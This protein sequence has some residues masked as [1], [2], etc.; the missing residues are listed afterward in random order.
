L[1]EYLRPAGEL[2]P[3]FSGA[4]NL[5]LAGEEDLGVEF[6]RVC[7]NRGLACQVLL[8]RDLDLRDGFS[9]RHLVETYAP[10]AVINASG[11]SVLDHGAGETG[12]SHAGRSAIAEVSLSA[13]ADIH[14]VTFSGR[15][16]LQDLDQASAEELM[17][18]SSPR[19]EWPQRDR[20]AHAEEATTRAI[21][22]EVFSRRWNL[23]HLSGEP[24]DQ[25]GRRQP[26]SLTD[27]CH[28]VLDLLIDAE[29][30][31]QP[32]TGP[33]VGTHLPATLELERRLAI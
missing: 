27:F 30:G 2:R 1:P 24:S 17:E 10:W 8:R 23:A 7:E 19:I 4:P 6:E 28:A 21:P 14:L 18:H 25:P 3:A 29:I 12:P 22:S 20:R 16:P 13:D 15:S 26:A 32:S 33:A 9:L 31:Q 11:Y 5:I